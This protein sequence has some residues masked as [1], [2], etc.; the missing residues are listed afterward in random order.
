MPN[1][2]QA[3][4]RVRQDQELATNRDGLT[5]FIHPNTGDALA[6]HTAHA[7]WMG[8]LLPLNLAS[9]QSAADD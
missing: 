4:R 8:E 6:D 2:K 3:K 5:V 9:L 1:T 7:I